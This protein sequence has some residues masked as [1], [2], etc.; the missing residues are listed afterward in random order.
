MNM[1]HIVKELAVPAGGASLRW[2][3]YATS[4]DVK[5]IELPIVLTGMDPPI[6]LRIGFTM[7]IVGG[8]RTRKSI[9]NKLSLLRNSQ[10]NVRCVMGYIVNLT[11]ILDGIFKTAG[12]NVTDS[13]IIEVT[14]SHIRSGRRDSI[15]QHIRSFVTETFAIWFAIP[16]VDLILETIIDL[17]RQY[18]TPG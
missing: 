15:H 5:G 10:E 16:Q 7:Y 3:Y 4:G 6:S 13:V 11:V 1:S 12:G 18:C 14:N 2:V 9:A 17:I 8:E